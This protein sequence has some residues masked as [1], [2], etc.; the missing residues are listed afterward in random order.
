MKFWEVKLNYT[1]TPGR[2]RKGKEQSGTVK[3]V[4]QK[5]V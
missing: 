2:V 5:K 4:E 3:G 1:E